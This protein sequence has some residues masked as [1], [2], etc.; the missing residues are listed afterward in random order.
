M[1]WAHDWH[2]YVLTVFSAGALIGDTTEIKAT[3]LK[4]NHSLV[5]EERG[6][7]EYQEKNLE[8]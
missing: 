4:S 8:D 6:K 1:C 2:F 3:Q 7:S 5:F